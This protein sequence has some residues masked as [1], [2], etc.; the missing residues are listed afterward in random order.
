MKSFIKMITILI[1]IL[2]FNML[3][4]QKADD[5]LKDLSTQTNAYENIKASFS[6]KMQNTAADID[7]STNGTLI[8][9][10]NKYNLNIAG[11]IVISDGSTLW[12]YIPD[13][14]EVQINEV[15]EEEGFS[16]NKLLSSYNDEYDA[17]MME[18][19]NKEGVSFYQLKLTPKDENSNFDYVVLVV[20]KEKMQ[21]ANFIMHDFDGNIFSYEIKQFIT[22][23]DIPDGSFSFDEAAHPNV[24]VIDM[25]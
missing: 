15:S 7:E 25:R 21:L 6:Y 1:V 11:Q 9:A 20:N 17:E 18:D 4:A 10:G 3:H 24:E 19:L 14:E 23:S 5:I 13:S 16:P 12:T 2:S 22:N 8:V